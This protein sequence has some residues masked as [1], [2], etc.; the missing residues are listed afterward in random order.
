M[1]NGNGGGDY[2]DSDGDIGKNDDF[3]KSINLGNCTQ[4]EKRIKKELEENGM[5]DDL[6]EAFLGSNGGVADDDQILRELIKCQSELKTYTMQN[7][8]QL[9]ALLRQVKKD[10][11]KQDL[12]KKLQTADAEVVEIYR[13]MQAAK[14]KKRTPT[15]KEKDQATKALK[16][17]EEI[18]KELDDVPATVW[19]KQ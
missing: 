17:R 12:R 11:G 13:R 10:F 5:L 4:L 1:E 16:D 18:L 6:D 2:D 7:Q 8:V 19:L 3:L 15:K 9:Q 14:Q